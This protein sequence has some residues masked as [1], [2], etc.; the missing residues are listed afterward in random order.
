M[1]PLSSIPEFAMC[2]TST[3]FCLIEV[4]PDKSPLP[5]PPAP[6]L[7]R[8]GATP[9]SK[10]LLPPVTR[11]FTS[12]QLRGGCGRRPLCQ[13]PDSGKMLRMLKLANGYNY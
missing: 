8:K 12:E 6:V 7:T 9:D 4:C 1:T 3:F 2:P 11:S 5:S 13:R 10:A